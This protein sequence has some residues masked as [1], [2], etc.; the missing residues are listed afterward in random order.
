MLK[1]DETHQVGQ[2]FDRIP[3]FQQLNPAKVRGR[4]STATLSYFGLTLVCDLVCETVVST[5]G[6]PYTVQVH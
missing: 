4:L 6:S 2:T 5:R 1:W 3:C